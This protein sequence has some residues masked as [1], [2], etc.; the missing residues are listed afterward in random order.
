[1][2]GRGKILLVE[3]DPVARDFLS[4][5]FQKKGCQIAV[6]ENGKKAIEK[7]SEGPFDLIFLDLNMP[8]M[9]GLEALPHLRDRDQKV[10]IVITTAFASYESKIE[11]REHGV[12]DYLVKPV[13]LSKIQELAEKYLPKSGD[14][15]QVVED[16]GFTVGLDLSKLDIRVAHLVPENMARMH[17]LIPVML[18]QNV[19]TVAMADPGNQ[20][21]VHQLQAATGFTILSL[22]ADHWDILEAIIRAYSDQPA[23]VDTPVEQPIASVAA[24]ERRTNSTP[25]TVETGTPDI[26]NSESE[27]GALN[28]LTAILTRAIERQAQEIHLDPSGGKASI[29]LRA[30]GRLEAL[31]EI[32]T[33]EYHAL[34]HAILGPDGG[35]AASP[36]ARDRVHFRRGSQGFHYTYHVLPTLLGDSMLIYLHDPAASAP[37]VWNLDM[38]PTSHS[39]LVEALKRPW[40][41]LSDGSPRARPHDNLLR[42]LVL[43]EHG[44]L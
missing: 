43:R 10:H 9:S 44:R 31:A 35:T 33:D 23:D 37:D 41:D 40:Y 24:S 22:K 11:A 25:P 34:R 18:H 12:R 30:H 29:R 28:R 4:Q 8:V 42:S 26:V 39:L 20:E 5:F 38:D 2:A 32:S 21:V 27:Q 7:M 17:F 19:L 1:M 14:S 3:D 6:A 16:S 13:T 15:E 36:H